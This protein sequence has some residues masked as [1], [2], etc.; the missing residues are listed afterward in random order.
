MLLNR[1]TQQSRPRVFLPFNALRYL[2][3]SG[4]STRPQPCA[5]LSTRGTP[6]LWERLL[7]SPWVPLAGRRPLRGRYKGVMGRQV[8]AMEMPGEPVAPQ[9]SKEARWLAVEN[10]AV[11]A[12]ERSAKKGSRK[13]KKRV[14]KSCTSV[15]PERPNEAKGNQRKGGCGCTIA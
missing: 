5:F 13:S 15:T 7:P 11:Q 3:N 14:G 2:I 8:V 10:H 1:L 12:R 9:L 4:S 6:S